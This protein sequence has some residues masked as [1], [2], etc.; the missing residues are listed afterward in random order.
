MSAA[1]PTPELVVRSPGRGRRAA[2]SREEVLATAR[3]WFLE[4][5]RV[6]V[7]AIAAELGVGRATIYRWYGSREGLLAEVLY[8]NA[9]EVFAHAR[10]VAGGTGAEHA[11]EVFAVA[12]AVFA[13]SDVLR[14]WVD[15]EREVAL[16]ILTDGTGPF[17]P[18]MCA[19]VQAVL[20]EQVDAGAFDPPVDTPTL[21]Y[22]IVR[23]FE[24]FVYGDTLAGVT[25]DLGRLRAVEAALLGVPG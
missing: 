5:R 22:A 3:A 25:R 18:R 15:A 4:G 24:A 11:L 12:N 23:L 10:R 20:D 1:E 9:L 7:R 16:R 21:A 13:G 6:D 17:Q 2:A 8:A 19:V 14:A